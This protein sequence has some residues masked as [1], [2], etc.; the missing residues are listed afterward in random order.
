MTV[1]I[2]IDDSKWVIQASGRG[3]HGSRNQGLLRDASN[4]EALPQCRGVFWRRLHLFMC[5]SCLSVAAFASRLPG[6]LQHRNQIQ[7]RPFRSRQLK[8]PPP[9]VR[10]SFPVANRIITDVQRLGIG[11]PRLASRLLVYERRRFIC[12]DFARNKPVFEPVGDA[13]LRQDRPEPPIEI[14]DD[15]ESE[16]GA[17]RLQRRNGVGVQLP[18]ARLAKMRIERIEKPLVPTLDRNAAVE[19]DP[20]DEHPPPPFVVIHARR[21]S[22]HRRFRVVPCPT[23]GTGQRF[24]FEIEP[25]IRCDGSIMPRGP[26][27]QMDQCARG[28]EENDLGKK[29]LHR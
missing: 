7:Q 21:S 26:A 9:R 16:P 3:I 23:K 5:F 14:G 29:G 8:N 20:P 18:Y 24:L 6:A 15:P 13:H 27:R 19:Q 2:L 4:F 17:Q 10:R 1:G 12:A 28:V 11:H 25:P 22:L